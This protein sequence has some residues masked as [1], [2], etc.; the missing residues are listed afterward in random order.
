MRDGI[1]NLLGAGTRGEPRSFLLGVEGGGPNQKG[2]GS[3][4]LVLG[5]GLTGMQRGL[6]HSRG[7]AVWEG[8]GGV[9]SK[10]EPKR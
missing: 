5:V 3:D 2:E 9:G 4:T 8:V 10:A 6:R 7:S 1:P